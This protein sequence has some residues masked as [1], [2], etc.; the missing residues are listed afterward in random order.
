MEFACR[1]EHHTCI[2]FDTQGKSCKQSLKYH[3]TMS[4]KYIPVCKFKLSKINNTIIITAW[5]LLDSVIF[6]SNISYLP[7]SL[8]L[9][10]AS[11]LVH[12][13]PFFRPKCLVKEKGERSHRNQNR[14]TG[15]EPRPGVRAPPHLRWTSAV[16]WP[17]SRRSRDLGGVGTLAWRKVRDAPES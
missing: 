7:E 8:N 1:G 14:T 12:R 2:H 6:N 4:L 5:K 16:M 3:K 10:E 13:A 15:H 11:F 9:L 17:S